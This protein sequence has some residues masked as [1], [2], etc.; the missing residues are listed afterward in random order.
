MRNSCGQQVTLGA[1]HCVVKK[2]RRDE[3]G[4]TSA[5]S[6][7]AREHDKSFYTGK[8]MTTT[9]DK[10]QPDCLASGA[11]ARADIES[12][13]VDWTRI[14][15]NAKRFEMRIAKAIEQGRLGKARALQRLLT[16]SYSGKMLTMK[17]DTE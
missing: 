13:Q 14:E 12:D 3:S 16:H 2:R 11:P 7:K 9:D 17:R 1:P 4:Q 8:Q 15:A 10:A 6:T 5:Q